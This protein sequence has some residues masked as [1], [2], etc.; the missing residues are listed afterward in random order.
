MAIMVTDE[1][2]KPWGGVRVVISGPT[3]RS[4]TT[5]SGGQLRVTGLQ[6]GTYRLRFSSDDVVAFEREVTV[7]A[8]QTGDIDV[9]LTA[10]PPPP[11]PPA[12]PAPQEPAE[13]VVGPSGRT[14]ATSLTEFLKRNQV[15]G[16]EPRRDTLIS[17]S[18][19]TRAMLVQMNQDQP[20]RSYANAEV[21]YYVIQGEGVLRV[22]MREGALT[23]GT[24]VSVPRA[25]SHEILRRGKRPLVLIAQVSGEPC[26]EAK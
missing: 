2:G 6:A 12:A 25:T 20:S 15:G 13:P 3:E 22:D 4:G 9:T 14:A 11:P 24:F 23:P 17:C 5:D 19:N 26:E 18:G 8:G 1:T 16:T 10:A 21:T 7:R